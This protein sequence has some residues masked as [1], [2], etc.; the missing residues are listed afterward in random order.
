MSDGTEINDENFP[1]NSITSRGD[2]GERTKKRPERV[3]KGRAIRRKKSLGSNLAKTFLGNDAKSVVAYIFYEVLIPAAKNTIQDMITGG[4]EMLLFGEGS[5]NRSRRHQK[6]DGQSVVSYSNYYQGG[7]TRG[8]SRRNGEPSRSVYRNRTRGIEEII[9]DDRSEAE[10]VLEALRDMLDEYES[11]S[12]A[13]LMDLT[14]FDNEDWTDAKWGWDD[15]RHAKVIRVRGGYMLDL[16][17][18]IAIEN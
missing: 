6:R 9:I 15:L 8:S 16:P 7:R 11:V 1:S 4:I 17:D 2:R 18:P 12:V 5:G 14:G 10:D 13:D 3:V